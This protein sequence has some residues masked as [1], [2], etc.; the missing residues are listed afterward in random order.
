[1]YDY[2]LKDHLGNTRVVFTDENTDG[3][4]E[5]LQADNYYPFGMIAT[6]YSFNGGSNQYLYNGKELQGDFSLNWYDY[7]AR[8]YDPQLGRF[9]T[10]DPLSSSFYK[11]TPYNYCLDNPVKLFESNGAW[12]TPIHHAIIGRTF[13]ST[14][15]P[16]QIQILK[17]ASDA[18]DAFKHQG[19]GDSYMHSM[20]SSKYTPAQAQVEYNNFIERQK[21]LFIHAKDM[22]NALYQLGMAFH[23]IMDN[24]CPPHS[25][26]Q[27]WRTRDAIS[28]HKAENMSVDQ[29]LSLTSVMDAEALMQSILSE[30][31][32]ARKAAGENMTSD[33]L[34]S[35]NDNSQT[36]NKSVQL[37]E[38]VVT[39]K[40]PESLEQRI[41]N[42]LWQSVT[43]NAYGNTGRYNQSGRT[44]DQ[45]YSDDFLKWYYD[46]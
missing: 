33:G 17:N 27:V 42:M 44:T 38:V 39:A 12:P 23:A 46:K 9:T 37:D 19:S 41:E 4:P 32:E 10:M 7:S 29:A 45:Y 14:L 24:S 26:F 40:K 31:M 43:P 35:S 25:G 30:V 2:Y 6:Q 5:I 15:S 16:A 8:Y 36:S 21:S 18:S 22:D 11:W 34:L 20:G 1:V 28:H 13:G 3:T